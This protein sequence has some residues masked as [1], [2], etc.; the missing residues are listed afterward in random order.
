MEAG[1]TRITGNITKIFGDTKT[2]KKAPYREFTVYTATLDSGDRVDY[3]FNR[4]PVSE[5]DV[6]DE[7][8]VQNYG[9]WKPTGGKVVGITAPSGAGPAP[10]NRAFPVSIEHG[11]MAI[12]RQNA[13][14]NAVKAVNAQGLGEQ[15]PSICCAPE[16]DL[17]D[18]AQRKVYVDTVIS[19]AYEFADF[20][21]GRRE[22][23]AAHVAQEM[24]INGD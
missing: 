21:S 15:D 18:P 2:S 7:M 9:K 5:G 23:K 6:F 24:V 10:K 1:S 20:S 14:T 8:C 22:E 16:L 11:S 19:I 4:P 3:G 17:T 13:L 12:I